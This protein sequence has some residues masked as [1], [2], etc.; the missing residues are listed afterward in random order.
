MARE[1][2]PQS[3]IENRD[4]QPLTFKTHAQHCSGSVAAIIEDAA[5]IFAARAS[6]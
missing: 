2:R 6:F 4:Y 1:A 5:L 3:D